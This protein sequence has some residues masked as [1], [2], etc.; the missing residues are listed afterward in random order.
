VCRDFIA[1]G[2]ELAE[3]EYFE[4]VASERDSKFDWKTKGVSHLDAWA[5]TV[6]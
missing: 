3:D 5:K 6:K 4:K 1:R 2:I